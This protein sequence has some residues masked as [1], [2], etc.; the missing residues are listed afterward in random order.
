MVNFKKV[1]KAGG[2]TIPLGLRRDLNI[3]PGDSLEFTACED[4]GIMI[5][6][7][8]A[9][10]MFCDDTEDVSMFK[11]KPLCKACKDEIVGGHDGGL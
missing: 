11:C 10:C 5:N 4:G 9:H 2:V 8:I 3:Q 7:H 1:S 6:R